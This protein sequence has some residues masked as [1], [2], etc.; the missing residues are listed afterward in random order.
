[1][2]IAAHMAMMEIEGSTICTARRRS[3]PGRR[4]PRPGRAFRSETPW[5]INQSAG[6]SL[7]SFR[8]QACSRGTWA[9]AAGAAH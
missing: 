7:R 4:T 8:P 6:V 5:L 2:L 3:R 9:R 1:M